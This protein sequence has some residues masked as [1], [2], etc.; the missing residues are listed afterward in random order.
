MY[1]TIYY[2]LYII[3]YIVYSIKY[4]VYIILYIHFCSTGMRP[5]AS[6][7][8]I[9]LICT[10]S[11]SR[12]SGLI[13]AMSDLSYNKKYQVRVDWRFHAFCWLFV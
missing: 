11:V 8:D 3:Y 13:E 6:W 1:N 5:E 12:T 10:L 2:I 4:I 9:Q 7:V